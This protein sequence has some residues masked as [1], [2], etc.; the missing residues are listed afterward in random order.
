MKN[1]NEL[2]ELNYIIENVENRIVRVKNLYGDVIF[3]IFVNSGFCEIPQGKIF[4]Y[5]IDVKNGIKKYGTIKFLN[6]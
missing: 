1:I 6:L 3:R 5:S 2:I 4:N